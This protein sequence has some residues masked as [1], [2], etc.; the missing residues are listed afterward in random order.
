VAYKEQSSWHAGF[1]N[2]VSLSMCDHSDNDF[3]FDTER[4]EY[5]FQ[6]L[7]DSN[8]PHDLPHISLS[9]Y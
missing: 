2:H 9:L 3:E 8:K 1:P 4:W 6:V 7:K 5:L